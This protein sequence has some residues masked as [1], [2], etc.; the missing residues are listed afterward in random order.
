M[1]RL[2]ASV[3]EELYASHFGGACTCVGCFVEVSTEEPEGFVVDGVLVSGLGDDDDADSS[4]DGDVKDKTVELAAVVSTFE[5]LLIV[6]AAP[7][8]SR[9]QSWFFVAS[10]GAKRLPLIWGGTKRH[11][12]EGRAETPEVVVVVQRVTSNTTVLKELCR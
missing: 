2:P 8:R 6:P 9:R 5:L 10:D 12:D 7:P 1:E 4:W 3:P 11:D